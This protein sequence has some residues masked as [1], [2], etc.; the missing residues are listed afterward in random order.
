[1]FEVGLSRLLAIRFWHHYAF[2]IISCALLGYS[3]SGVWLLLIRRPRSPFIP[4]LIFSITL[5]PFLILFQHLPFD[6]I[7]LSLEPLQ[8]GYLFLHYL[9]LALPFFFCGLVINRLLQEFSSNAFTL[10]CGDL[11]G[12]AF[13]TLTFFLIASYLKEM[14]W[15]I[16]VMIF[17]AISSV[18]LAGSVWSRLAVVILI[19]VSFISLNQIG[20]PEWKMSYY[21]SLP[22]ALQQ[23]GSNPI[24]TRSDAVS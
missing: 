13:G 20:I 24:E 6:P 2:L 9:I 12:A 7:L 5:I 17:G 4:S 18:C 23:Y 1:M 22:L 8:W 11:I 19:I 16:V 14:E 3:M 10:Y 21:K 15:L